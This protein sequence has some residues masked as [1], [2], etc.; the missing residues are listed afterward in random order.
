MKPASDL[1]TPRRLMF[2]I[3]R[4]FFPVEQPD[5]V[6]CCTTGLKNGS[7]L[8][9]IAHFL[10]SAFG[11][12]LAASPPL[13]NTGLGAGASATGIAAATV[14]GLLATAGFAVVDVD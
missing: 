6:G 7:R 1:T 13:S 2:P 8:P 9:F 4:H 5:P 11:P 10:S 12:G 3:S 14:A